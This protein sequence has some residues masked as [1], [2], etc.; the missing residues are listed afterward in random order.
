MKPRSESAATKKSYR[1]AWG[2]NRN[3][4]ASENHHEKQH[5]EE[6]SSELWGYDLDPER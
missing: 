2:Y 6:V 3:K 5:H 1:E 4:G